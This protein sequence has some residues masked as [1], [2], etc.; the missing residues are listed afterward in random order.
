MENLTLW[1]IELCSRYSP[2]D[3]FAGVLRHLL[4]TA[5]FM[6]FLRMQVGASWLSGS[7]PY[8][9]ARDREFDRRVGWIMLQSCAPIGKALWP[10]VHFLDPGVSGYL[11]GQ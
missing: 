6:A 9:Q 7:M 2:A 11:V 3:D 10:H 8:L 5:P 4:R 1:K